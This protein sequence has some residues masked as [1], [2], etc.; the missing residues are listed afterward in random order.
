MWWCLWVGGEVHDCMYVCVVFPTCVCV[1]VA[2]HNKA[3]GKR[4][5]LYSS[6]VAAQ[7]FST[8]SVMRWSA[9]VRP[10]CACV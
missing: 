1:W 5:R 4:A 6:A 2:V 7:N 8:S 3:D 10:A 9:C